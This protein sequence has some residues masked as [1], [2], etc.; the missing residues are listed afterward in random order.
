MYQ[1]TNMDKQ[2]ILNDLG[3]KIRKRRIELSISQKELGLRI[4]KDQQAIN[5]LE[6]GGINPS[7]IQL[8]EVCTGLELTIDEL[9]KN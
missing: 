1:L 2:K 4:D 5:R 9:L 7:Y 8:L 3:E 6:T